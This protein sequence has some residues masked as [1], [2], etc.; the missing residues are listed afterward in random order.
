[1][2]GIEQRGGSPLEQTSLLE[3]DAAFNSSLGK[4]EKG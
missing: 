4:Y 1:M 3:G 2:G